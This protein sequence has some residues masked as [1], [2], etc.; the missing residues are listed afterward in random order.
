MSAPLMQYNFLAPGIQV[1]IEDKS[2]LYLGYFRQQGLRDGREILRTD[3][4]H[5]SDLR[6]NKSQLAMKLPPSV[7]EQR[8]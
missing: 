1:P 8:S 2:N 5:E 7:K 3:T 4:I 6:L